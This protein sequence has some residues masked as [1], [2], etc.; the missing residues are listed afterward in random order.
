VG[1]LVSPTKAISIVDA[2]S[3]FGAEE[4]P[5]DA[6]G[7]DMVC[8]GSQ[9]AIMLPPGLALVSASEKARAAMKDAKCPAFYL[10]LRKYLKELPKDTT[11]FTPPVNLIF[12]LGKALDMILEE[13]VESSWA[14]HRVLSRAARAAMASIGLE[15]YSERPSVVV[16]TVKMPAGVEFGA[17][18]H[19]LKSRGITIAG[20]Q[21]ELKGKIFRIATLGYY[22]VFD[23]VTIVSAVEIALAAAGYSFEL[24]R[25]VTTAMEVLK[26]YSPAKGWNAADEATREFEP[27]AQAA[28]T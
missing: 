27:A 16:T 4:L 25:G 8:T 24:G 10:D 11:P 1:R 5:Q 21:D 7:I 17:F 23:V 6:W 20:G 3:S 28:A 26:A 12:A 18:N 13:G 19:E 2:V 22:N 15:I 9:K 14:R